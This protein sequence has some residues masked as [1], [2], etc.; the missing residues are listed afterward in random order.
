MTFFFS[1]YR[2]SIGCQHAQLAA[3]ENKYSVE[4]G[5][6]EGM[7]ELGLRLKIR[8]RV[9]VKNLPCNLSTSTF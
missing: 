6:G 3:H 7:R 5:V 1:V 4:M 2:N 9:L 8:S